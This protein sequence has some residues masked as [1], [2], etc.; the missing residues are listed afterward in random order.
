[1]A[2][3]LFWFRPSK[4]STVTKIVHKNL[5]KVTGLPVD[6]AGL[7]RHISITMEFASQTT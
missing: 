1:M 7:K 2:Q 5:S 4:N 6:T 3:N